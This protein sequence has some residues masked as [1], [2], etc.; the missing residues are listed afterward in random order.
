MEHALEISELSVNYGKTA[1]LWDISLKIPKGVLVAIVGPNGAGKTTFLKAALGL[2]PSLSGAVNYGGKSIAYVPQRETVDW[3][4]PIT[5]RE[6]V[7]M[8]RYGKIGVF[9][10]PKKSDWNAADHYLEKVGL[11]AYA[12]HQINQLSGGQQ[13]R[14]FIARALIQEAEILFLD[15]P[16]VGIDEGSKQTILALFNDLRQMG[17]TL[18]VV[19]HDL[20]TVE[21][22]F[23][24][25]ILL[26]TRLIASGPV[27]NVFTKEQL[28]LTFGKNY[29]LF[30]EALKLSK[31]TNV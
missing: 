3:D 15:E 2:I 4:F 14:A 18:L 16:F 11:T 20:A 21:S 6:L 30:D 17:K 5:V 13:Q 22:I 25:V 7:L 31:Q 26:N 12:S 1:A 27:E 8:G 24:W 23:N 9:R 29:T 10:F 19:H 28:A